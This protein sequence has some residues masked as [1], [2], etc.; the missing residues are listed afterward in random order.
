MDSDR[1]TEARGPDRRRFLMFGGVSVLSSAVLAACAGASSGV[2]AAPTTGPTSTA[3]QTPSAKDVTL[4]RTAMSIEALAVSVY[5]KAIKGGLVTTPAVLALIK[6][7]QS[8]HKDH[9]ELFGR[10]I[11]GAGGTP[12]ADPNPVL[13]QQVVT[14]RLAALKSEMDVIN[15]AYDVE[16]LAAATCQAD[17]GMF[18]NRK[19]NVATASVGGAEA[20]H[21]ALLAVLNTR[22]ATG[23]PDGAF[24][25][26]QDAVNP[27]TGV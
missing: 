24:Q 9:G 17:I 12:F 1:D 23:T 22:S 26:D 10:N 15:L 19:Y 5:D 2:K 11:T 4:L 7:F 20:R 6:A 21:V 18:D 25:T 14:P 27:G 16:R 3:A 8:H 13:L